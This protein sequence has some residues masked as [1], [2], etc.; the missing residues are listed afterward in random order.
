M[1]IT[2]RGIRIKSLSISRNDEGKDVTTLTYQLM[3]TKDTVL[4]EKT[5]TTGRTYGEE[6]FA[7]SAPAAE[8][9]RKGVDAVKKEIE[10]SLGFEEE[11][12]PQ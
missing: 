3:S 4:A 9:M 5:M 11:P 10:I 2:V 6:T 1:A 7:L 8:A 12:T